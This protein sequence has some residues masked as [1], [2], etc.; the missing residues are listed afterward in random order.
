VLR[1]QR[2]GLHP[3]Y[4]EERQVYNRKYH[5]PAFLPARRCH[6]TAARTFQPGEGWSG[7][8]LFHPA[9]PESVPGFLLC[10]HGSPAGYCPDSQ[11]RSSHSGDWSNLPYRPPHWR[12]PY[13]PAFFV[14]SHRHILSH[15]IPPG[16]PHPSA[17]RYSHLFPPPV[18]GYP[19]KAVQSPA[20]GGSWRCH[21]Y[22]KPYPLPLWKRCRYFWHFLPGYYIHS[23]LQQA[24]AVPL[25]L[26][27]AACAGLLQYCPGKA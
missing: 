18:P 5:L 7:N 24:P 8:C 19:R 16:Y 17:F 27:S 6:R 13:H 11:M 4:P 14:L 22:G 9:S 3:Q 15:C 10:C 20:A 26:P 1:S 21:R 25:T 12:Y 23:P 2:S